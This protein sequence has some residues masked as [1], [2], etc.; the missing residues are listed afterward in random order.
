MLKERE[1]LLVSASEPF[2]ISVKM[3]MVQRARVLLRIVTSM[4]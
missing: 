1:F 4:V 2:P 3:I